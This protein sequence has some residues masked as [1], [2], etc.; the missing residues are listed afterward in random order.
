MEHLPP[1]SFAP[2]K[3]LADVVA[4]LPL[5]GLMPRRLM[6]LQSAIRTI[7]GIASR[8]PEQLP[9]DLP[10]LRRTLAPGAPGTEGLSRKTLQNLKSNLGAAIAASGLKSA[11]RTAGQTL[12]PAWAMALRS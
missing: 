11:K 6:D 10:A 2:A 5:A 12:S 9:L 4:A 8:T 7:C 1:D 3:T